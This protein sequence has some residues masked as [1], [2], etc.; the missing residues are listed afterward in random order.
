[1]AVALVLLGHFSPLF[2]DPHLIRLGKFGVEIF[3]V[4]SGF[5]ITH[6]LLVEERLHVA[7]SVRRF[8]LRRALRILPALTCYLILLAALAAMGVFPI[9]VVDLASSALFVRNFLGESNETGHLWTLAIEEQFYFVWP[10]FLLWVR[11]LR[12]RIGLTVAFVLSAPLW[13]HWNLIRFGAD[14]VNTWRTDLRVQ[15]LLIGAVLALVSD[16]EKGRRWLRRPGLFGPVSMVSAATFLVVMLSTKWLDRPWVRV[17]VPTAGY[18]CCA[19]ILQGLVSCPEG[20]VVRFLE[21]AP[22]AATGR[23]SFSLYLWQQPFAPYAGQWAPRW[24]REFPANLLFAFSLAVASH[25]LVERPFLSLRSR[26]RPGVPGRQGGRD[27]DNFASTMNWMQPTPCLMR[28]SLDVYRGA[29]SSAWAAFPTGGGRS[30]S[31]EV[32]S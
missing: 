27:R 7:V 29:S 1:M 25:W 11:A 2:Q 21:S 8:W 19:W 10:L 28:G 22:I 9:P 32:P 24:F 17:G 20:G 3:F 4:L 18:V 31:S 13:L 23:L 26:L 6:L 14:Q 16:S 15:P 12:W 5:L 30:S